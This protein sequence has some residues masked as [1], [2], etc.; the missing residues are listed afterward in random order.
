MDVEDDTIRRYVLWHHRY[1]PQRHERRN[2]VLGAFDDERELMS[3][4]QRLQAEISRRRDAR[5]GSTRDPGSTRV[6]CPATWACPGSVGPTRPIQS[7]SA[8]WPSSCAVARHDTL[9]PRDGPE[10]SS[11]GHPEGVLLS[12]GCA[13]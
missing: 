12:H 11:G 9:L 1:D 10:H 13:Q 3:C 4:L 5:D 7:A 8:A 6:T 2:V